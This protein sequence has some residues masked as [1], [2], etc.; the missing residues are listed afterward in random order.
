MAMVEGHPHFTSLACGHVA[1]LTLRN[2][3]RLAPIATRKGSMLESW[4]VTL[5]HYRSRERRAA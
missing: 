3:I 5:T 4:E 2:G 1:V